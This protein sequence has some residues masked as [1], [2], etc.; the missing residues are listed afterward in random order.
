MVS[1]ITVSLRFR[2]SMAGCCIWLDGSKVKTISF[3]QYKVHCR[4]A[5]Q[6]GKGLVMQSGLSAFYT[7]LRNIHAILT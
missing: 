3:A 7:V 6:V 1:A 2:L 5:T 4:N